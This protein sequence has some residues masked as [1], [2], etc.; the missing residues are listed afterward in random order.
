MHVTNAFAYQQAAM[1]AITAGAAM[2]GRTW[3]GQRQH[4][5]PVLMLA[6]EHTTAD[7]AAA[8]AVLVVTRATASTRSETRASLS[9]TL[10]SMANSNYK[11][12]YIP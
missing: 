7:T 3:G 2:A 4:L 8:M 1:A 12:I 6:M 11:H 9:T 10:T 5:P